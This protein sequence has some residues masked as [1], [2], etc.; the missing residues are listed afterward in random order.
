MKS[1][2]IIQ[3]FSHQVKDYSDT[4][5]VTILEGVASVQD[6][7]V[8][9]HTVVVYMLLSKEGLGPKIMGMTQDIRIE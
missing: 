6:T 8:I 5:P 9:F 4:V 7:V 2:I 1:E 3:S